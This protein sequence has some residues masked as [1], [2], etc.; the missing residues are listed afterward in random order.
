[1]LNYHEY[2][3][4]PKNK[5]TPDCITRAL[6]NVLDISWDDALKLQFECALKTKYAI[7]SNQVYDRILK[8]HGY[9]KMKQP[10]KEDNR[11]YKLAEMDKVLKLSET[12][13]KVFV[14]IN[15]HCTVINGN[16]IEDIWDCREWTVRNYWVKE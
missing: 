14:N 10:R 2:N 15:H 3:A 6:S 8:E 4:N 7:G 11:K 13:N 12:K 9:I 1:M 16:T 5:K